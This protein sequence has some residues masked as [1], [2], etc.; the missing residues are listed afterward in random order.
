[1]SSLGKKVARFDSN[2]P[3]RPNLEK[4]VKRV[5]LDYVFVNFILNH[6]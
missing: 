2:I 3:K 5:E 1:M 6:S 4:N